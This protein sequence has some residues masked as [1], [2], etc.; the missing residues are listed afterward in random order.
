MI[1]N[2]PLKTVSKQPT[3]NQPTT[4]IRTIYP[5]IQLY[6][7]KNES[8]DKPGRLFKLRISIFQTQGQG[9]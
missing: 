4:I 3:T 6:D 8:F 1:I 9:M 2:T 7:C 5:Q